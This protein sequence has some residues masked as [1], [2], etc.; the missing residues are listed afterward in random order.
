MNDKKI[1]KLRKL[2]NK[3]TDFKL[4]RHLSEKIQIL[5]RNKT[6]LK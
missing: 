1:S 3:A 4:K 2:M 6:V 5:E